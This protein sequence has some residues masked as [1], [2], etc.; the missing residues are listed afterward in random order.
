M[1]VS[2]MSEALIVEF[3]NTNDLL[4]EADGFAAPEDLVAWLSERG[5]TRADARAGAVELAAAKEL[6]EGLRCLLL[7][8]NGIEDGCTDAW[9]CV[10]RAADDGHL[11]LRFDAGVPRM[12]PAAEG[13]R[14][15]LGAI[16]AAVQESVLEGG[17]QR[18]K[19]CRCRD[20]EW[21]FI[22]TSKN[23]SRA[24]CSMKVCGNREKARAFR[25][26]ERD[27]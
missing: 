21:A 13:V 4:A 22:D 5:L 24:W 23:R 19:A 1:L 8:N 12:R 10:E 9:A 11:V 27:S 17:F 3:V 25:A 7:R 6:R 20:C 18:I 2:K 15:A 16:V 14:G 26:R